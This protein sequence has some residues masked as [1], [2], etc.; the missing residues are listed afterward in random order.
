M[1]KRG[2]TYLE[3][4]WK[5]VAYMEEPISLRNLLLLRL[6]TRSGSKPWLEQS[7][8]R[9]AAICRAPVQHVR[10]DAP[11]RASSHRF[12]TSGPPL[13]HPVPSRRVC[14]SN[15]GAGARNRRRYSQARDWAVEPGYDPGFR[16]LKAL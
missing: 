14:G 8:R 4:I 13:A 5:Q 6:L 9:G 7:H 10:I 11:P 2:S 16:T 1:T 3:Q 15:S 12:G